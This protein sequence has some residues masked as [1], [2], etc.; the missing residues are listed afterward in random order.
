MAVTSKT[1]HESYSLQL[2]DGVEEAKPKTV[3]IQCMIDSKVKLTGKATGNIYLFSGAGS[4][5]EV[6]VEDKDEILNKKRG[7]SCCGNGNSSLFT[8]VEV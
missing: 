7:R 1:K 5:V 3:K 6:A 8:L 2:D 4:V